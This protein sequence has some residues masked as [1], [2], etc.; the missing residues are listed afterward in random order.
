MLEAIKTAPENPSPRDSPNILLTE[1]YQPKLPDFL[2]AKIMGMQDSKVFIDVRGIIVYLD[3]EY[4]SDAK[5]TRAIDVYSFGI[6]AL[7]ILL[8]LKVIELDLDV[9]NQFT[10]GRYFHDRWKMDNNKRLTMPWNFYL[11]NN[12]FRKNFEGSCQWYVWFLCID[13][14]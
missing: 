1:K 5:L 4:M 12:I 10:I 14:Q 13:S 11:V 8:G 7:Q 2:L 6:N 3:S 9:K